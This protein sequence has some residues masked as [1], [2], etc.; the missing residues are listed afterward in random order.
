MR[1]IFGT[2]VITMLNPFT[3]IAILCLIILTVVFTRKIWC[4]HKF[5]ARTIDGRYPVWVC[6]KCGKQEQK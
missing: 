1:Y 2:K 4:R 3:I 6:K 5:V